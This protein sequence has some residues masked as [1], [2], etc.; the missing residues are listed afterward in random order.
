MIKT[1]I[2]E[3]FD[4]KYGRLVVL[5]YNHA[6]DVLVKFVDTGYKCRTQIDKIRKGQIKDPYFPSLY[7]VGY[8]GVGYYKAK[9]KD[10]KNSKPYNVWLNMLGRCY[11][12]KSDRYNAYGAKG[13]TVC[14]EWHNYQNFAKWYTI[15]NHNEWELD[16][17]ILFKGNTVYSPNTCCFVP[18]EVN[19]L[20]TGKDSKKDL[21]SG[22]THAY[23][24]KYRVNTSKGHYG[25]Y[26]TLDDAIEVYKTAKLSVINK[27]LEKY[28]TLNKAI[29]DA[30]RK[31]YT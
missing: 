12:P 14:S 11:N 18:K 3:T 9:N 16:K 30:I 26:A 24:G 2:G 21:P 19:N 10:G 31:Q 5:E 29:I 1:N 23:G 28:P 27:V 8:F 4:G 15:N 25:T 22:V 6:K 20:L 7:G 13:V 17:D